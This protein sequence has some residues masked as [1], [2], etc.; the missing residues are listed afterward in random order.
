MLGVDLGSNT[1]RAVKMNEALEKL[2]EYEFIIG[3]A[4]NLG[5][6]KV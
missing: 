6:N 2:E 4:R 5:Q 1:L 3:A